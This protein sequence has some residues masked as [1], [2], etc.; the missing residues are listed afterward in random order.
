LR[1]LVID[2]GMIAPK[3]ARADDGN[4]DEVICVQESL[5]DGK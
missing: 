5:A 4:V 2:A 1:Q 3:G